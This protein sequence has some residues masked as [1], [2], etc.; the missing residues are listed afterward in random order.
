MVSCRFP[1]EVGFQSHSTGTDSPGAIDI[2]RTRA[3][4]QPQRQ[5]RI[6]KALV[7]AEVHNGGPDGD[8][9]SNLR[10]WGRKRETVRVD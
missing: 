7:C 4:G 2:V 6:G 3:V 8:G 1:D 10:Y 5:R 9:F